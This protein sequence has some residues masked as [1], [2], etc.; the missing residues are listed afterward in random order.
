MSIIRIIFTTI[1]FGTVVYAST[2]SVSG[3]IASNGQGLPGANVSLIGSNL[4]A[5][6]DSLGNYYLSDIPTGKYLLRVDYIGYE[7]QIK[8][9]YITL[10]D[11][12]EKDKT[13]SVLVDKLGINA[14]LEESEDLLKGNVLK[15]VNFELISSTLGLNEVIVSA[16]KRKQKI[17]Q[18]PSVVSVLKSVDIRR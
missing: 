14:D 2:G 13:G 16:S 18:A 6:T 5:V 1:F 7:S 9:I 12:D 3:T 15:N 17:T 11:L 4:G 10:Y 8:Q